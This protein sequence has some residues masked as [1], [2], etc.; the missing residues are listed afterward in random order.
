MDIDLWVHQVLSKFA[1][2]NTA[3]GITCTWDQLWDQVHE[4]VLYG[5]GSPTLPRTLIFDLGPIASGGLVPS[6][7]AK[8]DGS[9]VLACMLAMPHLY[10]LLCHDLRIL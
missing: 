3:Y 5:M 9:F 1:E 10:L 4:V 6:I 8:S 2:T 7:L